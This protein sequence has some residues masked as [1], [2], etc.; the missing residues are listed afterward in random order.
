MFHGNSYEVKAENVIIPYQTQKGKWA[1]DEGE[2]AELQRHMHMAFRIGVSFSYMK[3]NH[4][5]HMYDNNT[6]QEL[7]SYFSFCLISFSQWSV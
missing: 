2:S 1:E 3:Y 5:C 7:F 6:G 4:S